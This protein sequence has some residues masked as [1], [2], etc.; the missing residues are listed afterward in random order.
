MIKGIVAAA[1]FITG[2]SLFLPYTK[3]M[4]RE[5]ANDD[6]TYICKN[7]IGQFGNCFAGGMLLAI[8]IVHI[9]PDTI[10][11]YADWLKHVAEERAAEGR[12]WHEPSFPTPYVLFVFGFLLMLLLD[13]VIF[14]QL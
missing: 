6:K 7:R 12:E 8:S 13:Q 10:G 1:I 9:L 14:K 5:K 2:L 11:S 4:N 3:C